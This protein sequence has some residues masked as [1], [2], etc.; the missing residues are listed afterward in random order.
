M[1]GDGP[2]VQERGGVEDRYGSCFIK[3]NCG[4][5]VSKDPE[6]PRTRLAGNCASFALFKLGR[7][8][9]GAQ[10]E[11]RALWRWWAHDL[12]GVQ[13]LDA[14]RSLPASTSFIAFTALVT[15]CA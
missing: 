15:T 11:L 10:T 3:D 9:E 1:E 7:S 5:S 13:P 12:R 6:F 4:C 14:G 2:H 8:R